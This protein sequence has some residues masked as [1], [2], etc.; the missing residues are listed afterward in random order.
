[1]STI[2]LA[3]RLSTFTERWQPRTVAE[4]ES[5]ILLIEPT[6]TPN[7][8]DPS[9]AAARIVQYLHDVVEVEAG[10]FREPDRMWRCQ[11]RR[12]INSCAWHRR[13]ERR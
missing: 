6:G 10:G 9:T 13:Q 5:H 8:G 3:K 2:N 1:M 4:E 12:D 11:V 7:S